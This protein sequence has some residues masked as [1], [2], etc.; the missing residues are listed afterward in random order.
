MK[1]LHNSQRTEF[2][3]VLSTRED[4][5]SWRVM[6]PEGHGS[7]ASPLHNSV[8]TFP[9][10]LFTAVFNIL[11]NILLNKWANTSLFLSFVSCSGKLTRP[12]DG[13]HGN[14]GLHRLSA[15]QATGM[16]MGQVAIL[17]DL[18][19]SPGRVRELW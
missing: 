14:S 3:E 1:L 17:W 8:Y 2:Q 12:K 7:S 6:Y 4:G 13:C 9:V 19:L 10:W 5:G 18:M 16:C 15:A 11:W